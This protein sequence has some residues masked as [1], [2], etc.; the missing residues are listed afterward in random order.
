MLIWKRKLS[1]AFK[2]LLARSLMVFLASWQLMLGVF[3]L[4][5]IIG[6]FLDYELRNWCREGVF[7]LQPTYPLQSTRKLGTKKDREQE[8]QVQEKKFQDAIRTLQ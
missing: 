4:E 1:N 7:G 3:F 2:G 5:Q 8:Y 6:M